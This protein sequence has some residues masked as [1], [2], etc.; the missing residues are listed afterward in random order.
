MEGASVCHRGRGED[1]GRGEE[2]RG[3]GRPREVRPLRRRRRQLAS[4]V[5][6]KRPLLVRQQ[7]RRFRGAD[8]A[9]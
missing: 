6:A 7:V 8:V 1:S 9:R 4:A 2:G 5:C 3:R